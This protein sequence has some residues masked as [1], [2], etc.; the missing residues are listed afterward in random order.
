MMML[1][2]CAVSSQKESQ[3]CY[4]GG[5][6]SSSKDKEGKRKADPWDPKVNIQSQIQVGIRSYDWSGR[7]VKES[8]DNESIEESA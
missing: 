3:T 8:E 7:L 5:K 6:P 1:L 2:A 4:A